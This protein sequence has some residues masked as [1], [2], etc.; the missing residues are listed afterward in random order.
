MT[1]PFMRRHRT[2][3]HWM[4]DLYVRAMERAIIVG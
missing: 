1:D 3:W 2:A 4:N